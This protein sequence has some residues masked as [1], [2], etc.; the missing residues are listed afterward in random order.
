MSVDVRPY[1]DR[2]SG[3]QTVGPS[4]TEVVLPVPRQPGAQPTRPLLT[5][6]TCTPKYSAKYRLIITGELISQDERRAF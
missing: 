4:D 3:T 6:I 2:I 1:T 5:L